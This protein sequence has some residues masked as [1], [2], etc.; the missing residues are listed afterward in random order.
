MD[1][2]TFY[3]EGHKSEL[4]MNLKTYKRDLQKV[5]GNSFLSFVWISI[6]V[7]IKE[8]NLGSY[9]SNTSKKLY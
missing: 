2:H 5:I 4:E 7:F 6:L 9:R 3:A 1:Q 8:I